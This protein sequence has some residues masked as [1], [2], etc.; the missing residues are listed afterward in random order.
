MGWNIGW[1]WMDGWDDPMEFHEI[2]WIWMDL[3]G[4]DPCLIHFCSSIFSST[5]HRCSFWGSSSAS[6][7]GTSWCRRTCGCAPSPL[8]WRKRRT[9]GTAADMGWREVD[10]FDHFVDIYPWEQRILTTIYLQM[11]NMFV[12]KQVW[13]WG[14]WGY[15]GINGITLKWLQYNIVTSWGNPGESKFGCDM[16][17]LKNREKGVC[18][19]T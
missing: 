19:T 16:M 5:C 12:L 6:R 10:S 15:L 17:W 2:S 18:F 1:I 3:N 11:E 4:F 13:F 9:M 14:N 7:T 8:S